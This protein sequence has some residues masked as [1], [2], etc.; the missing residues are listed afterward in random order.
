MAKKGLPAAFG[1]EIRAARAVLELSQEALADRAGLHRN[2][3]GMIERAER[4]PTMSSIEALAKAL[5]TK[6]SE[7]VARA[8]ARCNWQK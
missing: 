2:Y 7:L 1:A 8:E 4:N 3:I 6:P 5:K